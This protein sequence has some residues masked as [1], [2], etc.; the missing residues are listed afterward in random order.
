[1]PMRLF[2]AALVLLLAACASA[3]APLLQMAPAAPVAQAVPPPPPPP[4][5][6]IEEQLAQL[7]LKLFIL[8][9]EERGRLVT[10]AKPL[11][12]DSN[13]SA[14]AQAHSDDMAKKR[15]FDAMNP[16]GNIAV[17][18]LL[19]DPKFHG[20]VGEN[21]A[22]Q[23]FTPSLGFDPD[24]MA[25]G[26]LD[27]WLASPGHKTNLADPRFERTGIGVAANGDAVYAAEIFADD[28]G[29]KDP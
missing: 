10:D 26:F 24:K 3:P 7:K 13:L 2:S 5:P 20:F 23:Y 19:A 11:A 12:L 8:V 21:A 28:L 27:I 14:A 6:P 22:A 17:N 9:A 4:P 25:R 18:A 29:L 15:S 1:M 16:D